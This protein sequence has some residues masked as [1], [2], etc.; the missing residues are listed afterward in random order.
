[1]Q[2]PTEDNN[3][4]ISISDNNPGNVEGHEYE[5][6]GC[7]IQVPV[8]KGV[9]FDLTLKN[10]NLEIKPGEL[11]AIVGEVGCGKSSLLQAMINSLI[12]LNPKEC[13]GIHIN[14]KVGYAAQIPWIQNDT[15]RNNILFS[16]P[17]DEDKYNRVLSLCQ[18]MED[19]ETFEGKDLT[20]IGE[21]GVNL[22]GGQKV[23]ISL[24]RTI[25]NEPDI[26]LFDD[27]ISALDANVGKKIMKN[28]IV[29]YLKGKTRIVVTHALSYL[30]YMD[31][32][33]YMKSGK[34]E[35]TGNYEQVQNQPFFAELAKSTGFSRAISG[36]IEENQDKKNQENKFVKAEDDDQIVKIIKE[37]EQSLSGVKFSVYLD[38][39]RYMGGLCYIIGVVIIS[40]ISVA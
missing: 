15:I 12:L 25:Y 38:Y 31:R 30:K 6:E 16:K 5:R 3:N 11:V 28:C 17:F 32:I 27:P 24:A 14:G 39:F 23:R 36:D 40:F 37:E 18:L 1:M 29:K 21:K 8:P 10:I 4:L 7:K 13:D 2:D 35:W 33:I 9:D 26:Y 19:L 34:I 22:S 20:E